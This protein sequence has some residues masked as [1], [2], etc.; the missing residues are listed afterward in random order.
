[1]TE[2]VLK[3]WQIDTEARINGINQHNSTG[4]KVNVREI[5]TSVAY[6]DANVTVVAFAV[7]HEEMINSSAINSRHP[8]APLSSPATPPLHRPSSTTAGVAMC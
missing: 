4:C 3:A 5:S 7:R 1:M 2:N 8:T 6:K